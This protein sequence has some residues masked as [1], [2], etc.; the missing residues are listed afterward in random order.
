MR[1]RGFLLTCT[2]AA[3]LNGT[4]GW[5][6]TGIGNGLADQLATGRALEGQPVNLASFG[7]LQ[8]WISPDISPRLPK[9]LTEIGEKHDALKL[10]EMPWRDSE[11]DVGVEWPEFRTMDKVV[12]RFS[13]EERVP[14]RGRAYLEYWSGLTTRQGQWKAF[15]DDSLLGIPL[16]ADSRTWIYPFSSRRTC[17]FRLR[18]QDQKHVEI[19]NLEVY[20]P[21]K[22]KSGEVYVEW[23]H[24]GPARAY[25]GYLESYN[26]QIIELRPSG[27]AELKSPVSWASTASGGKP[28]GIVAKVMYTWGMDVDR[29]ILTVRSKSGDF[30]FLPGEIVENQPIELPDFGVYIRNNLLDLD[31][32]LFRKQNAG[33]IRIIDAVRKHPEQTLHEARRHIRARRVTLSFIGMDSNSQKF[34]IAPDGHLVV[35]YGDPSGGRAVTAKFGLYFD[36]VGAS[37]L[38]EEPMVAV[39]KL[40]ND[41]DEKQQELEEGWLPLIV[42]RWSRDELSFERTDFA[43]LHN[44]PEIPDEPMLAGDERALMISRLSI[45]NNSPLAKTACYYVKP[46]KPASGDMGYGPIPAKTKNAWTTIVRNG[47]AMVVEDNREFAVCYVDTHGRGSV[48]LEAAV[49]ALRYREVLRP[50]DEVV[51]HIVVPGLPL[52]SADHIELHGL[53]YDR[54]HDS[55]VK[56][57]KIR[58]SEGMQV[59][60]PDRELQNIYN[61]TLHHWLLALTKDGRRTEHYPNVAM[62][63]YG[64]IGSESSPVIQSLDMRGIHKRAEGCLRAWLS[65][66]G[67][68]KPEGDYIS[69]EGGFYHFWPIYTIDQGAVLWALAE[70]YLYARDRAWLEKVATQIVA[71]CDFIIRE[72]KRTMKELPGGRKPLY[73]GSAPAGCVADPRD[74]EYS[75]MLNGYFYLGLKKSAQVL[76]DVDPDNAQRIAVEA[77]DYLQGIR[78]ALKESVAISPVTRLRDNTG[79]PTVPSYLGL[80]GLS[81]DA[82]D[83]VDPDARHAYAYDATIGPFHLLKSE[84]LQPE[85]PEVG[86]MLNYFEDR[87]FMFSPLQ[88]RVDLSQLS[89]D[90]FNMGGFEKLQ[91]YYVHYQDAYLQRD[92]I[93]NFLRGFFNTLA[94]ISDP[95]T[96]TFQEELDYDGAQPHKTHEEAWFFHQ[97]RFMLVMEMG[98]DLYLARGTP[99]EWLKRGQR[100]AVSRAPS[101]F[102]ELSYSIQSHAESGRIEATVNPPRRQLP[103]NLYLRLRH[104][105]QARMKRVSVNGESWSDFDPGKEWIRLPTQV[106]ELQVVAEF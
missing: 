78:K 88:S 43:A 40:F 11:F 5:A 76:Q 46:W 15:E 22:W 21:S 27:N 101:Y 89:T 39:D 42:T 66:Q 16:Q 104:P 74:W 2:Q 47:C 54:L 29:T 80:R 83:S 48:G 36:S 49:G 91:P 32:G 99:R 30:S 6:I 60:I 9:V 84:V 97:F 44:A 100:I 102:G 59:E 86:W 96:L 67:D 28:G 77:Q 33:K 52:P 70:H 79:V 93:P 19:Q 65:T 8:S 82:K 53:D 51:V 13:G 105:A 7:E 81:T 69:K 103:H 4:R 50:G 73:Y 23:G 90:W 92:E 26:G 34:G 14:A 31:L 58:L 75:F 72:R 63:E 62:L 20:G 35:G 87:L 37:K 71:G 10:A 98:N 3:L 18:L 17:K 45:R 38:F 24:L 25:D 85:D 55:A 94:A 64:C 57:W 68:S 12:V 41:S 56:Y 106:T 61:A 95:Q 1:R